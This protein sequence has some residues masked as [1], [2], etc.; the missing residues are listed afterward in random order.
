[1]VS[2]LHYSF[3]FSVI[4]I[5]LSVIVLPGF[6]FSTEWLPNS[7][8]AKAVIQQ[9]I[10][11]LMLYCQDYIATSSS[12]TFGQPRND[13]P[14][15]RKIPFSHPFSKAENPSLWKGR[16]GGILSVQPRFAATF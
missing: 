2:Y 1:M 3:K 14:D 5:H 7:R 11:Y 10:S 8:P 6:R 16:A 12:V 13:I 4:S 9:E 15:N